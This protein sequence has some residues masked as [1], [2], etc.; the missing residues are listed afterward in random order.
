M[1]KRTDKMIATANEVKAAL[2]IPA[3][4]L[5]SEVPGLFLKVRASKDGGVSSA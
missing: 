2:A 3:T 4:Y 1:G 5:D